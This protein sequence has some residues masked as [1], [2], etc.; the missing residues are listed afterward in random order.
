MADKAL[1]VP[2]AAALMPFLTETTLYKWIRKGE[3]AFERAPNGRKKIRESEVR[4]IVA[5]F[6]GT[7]SD[8]PR[9]VSEPGLSEPD[10]SYA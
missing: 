4:R 7:E 9:P 1:S 6:E 5:W 3:V 8:D 2:E 10:S